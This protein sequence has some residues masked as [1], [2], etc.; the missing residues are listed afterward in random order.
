MPLH[1]HAHTPAQAA[2]I[3][4]YFFEKLAWFWS[5][6]EDIQQRWNFHEHTRG[7]CLGQ[8]QGNGWMHLFIFALRS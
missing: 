5:W 4:C 8:I 3:I 6:V 7:Y 2:T 1:S